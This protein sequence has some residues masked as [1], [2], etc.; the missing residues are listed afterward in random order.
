M[1][2]T[3]TGRQ[4]GLTSEE[5]RSIATSAIRIPFGLRASM[6]GIYAEVS[7]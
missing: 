3:G 7:T 5:T 1:A 6:L 2:A 4:L